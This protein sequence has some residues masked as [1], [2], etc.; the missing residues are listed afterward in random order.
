MKYIQHKIYILLW[1]AIP[2]GFMMLY[3][4]IKDV[5]LYLEWLTT[6]IVVAVLFF[7]VVVHELC[8]GL[9]ARIG[10]DPT[11][12]NAG[13]LTFNPVRHVSLVGTVAVPL[14]L[15]LINAG[16]VIGWAKPVPFNPIRLRRH[17][18]DQVMLAMAGPLSNFLLAYLCFTLY[19]CAG[20][21]FNRLFPETPVSLHLDIST[22]MS[23]QHIP[24][25]AFW[26]VFFEFL[27]IGIVINIVLGIFNLIPFPPL[28]GSWILKSLLPKKA[29]AFLGKMQVFGFLLLFLALH[30][31]LLDVF[32]YPAGIVLMLFQHIA[33]LTLG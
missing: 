20:F 16:V 24:F 17:P 13:R 1:L 2:A 32:F 10:G 33:S 25:Q 31:R 14:F 27:E 23:F 7:S 29:S 21:V 11:A 12:E 22:P 8:H 18:R 26:F 28:D 5:P 15:H 3:P 19:L 9:A 6:G 30:F 4:Y